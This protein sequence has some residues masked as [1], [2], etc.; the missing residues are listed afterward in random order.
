MSYNLLKGKKGIIFGALDE[1]SI[2]WKT[3]LRC[4]EEGAS[5]LLTNA[6]VAM[7]MGEINKLAEKINWK[8]NIQKEIITTSIEYGRLLFNIVHQ[9]WLIMCLGFIGEKSGKFEREKISEAVSQY[10]LFWEE[11]EK[12]AHSPF[13]ASLYQGVYFN[14]PDA[15]EVKGLDESIEFYKK[16]AEM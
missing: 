15:P 4:H 8:D 3:A 10:N 2:A 6:P 1:R 11:Y 14:L 13:C 16:V 12:L 9:G 5:I 7:R